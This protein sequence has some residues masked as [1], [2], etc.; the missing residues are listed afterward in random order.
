M[1]LYT[2]YKQHA[3]DTTGDNKRRVE[4]SAGGDDELAISVVPSIN[5]TEI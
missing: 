3:S 2:D 1:W 5:R 4:A